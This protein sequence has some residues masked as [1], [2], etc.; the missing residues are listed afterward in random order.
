MDGIYSEWG[1]AE[2]EGMGYMS[3]EPEGRRFKSCPR[4]QYSII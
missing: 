1:E 3:S 4:Y 2:N